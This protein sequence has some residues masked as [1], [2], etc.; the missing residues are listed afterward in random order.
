[1]KTIQ[2][3]IEELLVV[4]AEEANYTK[5]VDA[6]GEKMNRQN[7][8][9]DELEALAKEQKT[10]L[11]RVIKFPHADSYAL[12]LVTKVNKK[13]A[14]LEWLDWCDGWVDDRCSYRCSIDLAYVLRDVANTDALAEMFKKQKEKHALWNSLQ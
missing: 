13:T 7:I 4:S 10:V 11:G 9:M 12:Y 6:L 14:Q 1:M 8:L 3:K 5:A 2:N